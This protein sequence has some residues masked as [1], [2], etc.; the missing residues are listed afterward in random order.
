[1]A[2]YSLFCLLAR[3]RDRGCDSDLRESGE[4]GVKSTTTGFRLLSAAVGVALFPAAKETFGAEM[5]LG[6]S[7]ACASVSTFAARC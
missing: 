2:A 1:M 5:L 6:K 3:L 4:V 7:G